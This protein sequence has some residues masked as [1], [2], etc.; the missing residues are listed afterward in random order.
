MDSVNDLLRNQNNLCAICE[1]EISFTAAEKANKPHI[2]H[3]HDTG[4]VRGLLC[5]TCNTGIG[6]FGDSLELL[7]KAMKYLD[8]F[9][10]GQRERLSELAP[11]NEGDA[12][13]RSHGKNNHEKPVEI[14][15]SPTIQ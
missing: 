9:E 13:V 15:G 7:E 8:R 3:N 12:T 10:S 4:E 5:L 1:R 6:M 11:F 14:A 2:D